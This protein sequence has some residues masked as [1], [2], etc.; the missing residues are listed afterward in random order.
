MRDQVE[1][2]CA[3]LEELLPPDHEARVV[4]E[5]VSRFD[6]TAW[7]QEVKAVEGKTGRNTT[8]PR[9]LL[10]L[11]V[12]ATVKGVG[13]ARELDRLCTRH[14]D[15]QWL[16]GGVSMNYHTLADFRSQGGDKWDGLLTELVAGLMAEGLV[17][18]ER[19]AQ[20]G[21]RVRANA[22]KSSFRRQKT[23]ERC[24]AEAAEQVE[25]L[26]RL[27]EENPEELT[28]RQQA[29]RERAARERTKA[30]DRGAGTLRGAAAAAGEAQRGIQR[31]GEGGPR[32]DHRP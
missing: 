29:A 2:R 25:T 4:W 32:F 7:L 14:I 3:S 10:A 19:V 26:K 20:D 27:A 31:A 24:R 8:D 23:L 1:F 5:A 28:R 22:G 11:W 18:L 9:L 6:L 15:Y 17:Q 30:S 13:S 16:C 21:M 12:Y